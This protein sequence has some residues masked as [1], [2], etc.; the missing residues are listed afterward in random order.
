MNSKVDVGSLI[1]IFSKDECDQI[2]EYGNSNGWSEFDH[3]HLNNVYSIITQ[4]WVMN[5]IFDYLYSYG[6][7]TMN[8]EVEMLLY[9]YNVGG[10]NRL[11][12]DTDWADTSETKY[13]DRVITTNVLLNNSFKGGELVISG[14][15][16][17]QKVGHICYHSARVP[18]E[19][20][21]VTEG[22]RYT[23]ICFIHNQDIFR[24]K[25]LL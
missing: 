5:R 15:V 1:K 14:E 9:K 10:K 20:K 22:E 6:N 4:S 3:M 2:I 8:N 25:H 13:N 19:V 7:I 24:K 18:H 23:L 16:Y 21:V 11:H 17:E 12:K